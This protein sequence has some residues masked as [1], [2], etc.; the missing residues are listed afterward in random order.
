MTTASAARC[1]TKAVRPRDIRTKRNR[2]L[3][4]LVNK[5][6]YDEKTAGSFPGFILM[7]DFPVFDPAWCGQTS[8]TPLPVGNPAGPI[9]LLRTCKADASTASN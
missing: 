2:K 8:Q 4:H 5:K 3:Q 1:R 6:I 9:S 7:F